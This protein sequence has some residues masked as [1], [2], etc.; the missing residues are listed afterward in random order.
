MRVAPSGAALFDPGTCGAESMM[1]ANA[2]ICATSSAS[3][4][5]WACSGAM[6]YVFYVVR[7]GLLPFLVFVG[8]SNER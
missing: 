6:R 3:I 5:S 2:G 4:I 1:A 8:P 7:W